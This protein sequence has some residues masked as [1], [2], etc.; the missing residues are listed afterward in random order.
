MT[1]SPHAMGDSGSD[2]SSTAGVDLPV[3]LALLA[4]HLSFGGF[5]VVAKSILTDLPPLALAGLRVAI[6][7][8][9]LLLLAWHKDR[10]LPRRRDL[11]AL[12]LLGALGV[13]INQILFITGLQYT[14]ATNAAIL[15]PSIPV[16]AVAVAA[17]LGIERVGWRR[18]LGI[19]L[20]VLGA[21]ILLGPGELSLASGSRFGNLLILLN[22]LSFAIFLVLQRPVL[23]RLPWRTTIAWAFLFGSVPILAFASGDL[24]Q[25]DFSTVST[26]SWLGL[27]YIVVLP[28]VFSYSVNTWAVK[29]SSPL[30]AASYTTAQPLFAA[31]LAAWFLGEHFGWGEGAGFLLIAAGLLRVSW[32]RSG[33]AVIPDHE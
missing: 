26:S 17:L 29:R 9:I 19:A 2:R 3:H 24:R 33:P 13:C 25:L 22:C 15:M 4:V 12:M 1:E 5:H 6:A 20:A 30:L 16:F 21:L 18:M 11:P 27:A 10:C 8:P 7:T 28:T 31:L 23:E 32:R 14:S